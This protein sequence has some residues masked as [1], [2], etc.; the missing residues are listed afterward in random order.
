MD[1]SLTVQITLPK[2]YEEVLRES[3]EEAARECGAEEAFD[4]A[5]VKSP[6]P[7]SELQFDPFIIAAGLYVA[8]LI[9]SAVAGDV[10]P[11]ALHKLVEK[12]RGAHSKPPESSEIIVI[13]LP[14]ATVVRLDVHDTESA[15]DGLAKVGTGQW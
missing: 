10:I 1:E 14:D 4:L 13:L 12:I 9:V 2:A 7:E 8:N 5:E 15:A 6:V 3:V 11:A